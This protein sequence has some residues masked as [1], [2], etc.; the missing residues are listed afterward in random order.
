MLPSW[1]CLHRRSDHGHVE[2]TEEAEAIG[3]AE[4]VL[5]VLLGKRRGSARPARRASTQSPDRRRS[6][7]DTLASVWLPGFR[8]KSPAYECAPCG[9][10]AVE[11]SWE[12]V[13]RRAKPGPVICP[14]GPPCWRDGRPIVGAGPLAR[15]HAKIDS[16]GPARP[17][18]GLSPSGIVLGRHDSN[19]PRGAREWVWLP[20]ESL[21]YCI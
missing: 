21:R 10:L 6:P 7:A 13:G 12:V 16:G 19:F 14:Y 17:G 11:P 20:P 3:L 9:P 4:Q 1:T 18:R 2:V 5:R 8:S 15:A